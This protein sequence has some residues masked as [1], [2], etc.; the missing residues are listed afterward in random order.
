MKRPTNDGFNGSYVTTP[1]A[2]EVMLL[3]GAGTVAGS[4]ALTRDEFAAINR[5]Y[6]YTAEPATNKP[7]RPEPP[8][9]GADWQKRQQY[10]EAVRAWNK[11][12]DPRP[13]MQAG[14]DRN[15]IRHAEC[16]G[17]RMLAWIAK[18]LSPG[19]DPVKALV[20]LAVDAGWDVDPSDVEW[21]ES[22]DE[23]SPEEGEAA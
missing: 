6:G 5:L 14:A 19:E 16:D 22:E 2:A 12:Q 23:E 3:L 21:S 18:R 15:A 13:H 10:E 17:L 1:T 11:W 8:P 20:R 4:V 7:P 9:P